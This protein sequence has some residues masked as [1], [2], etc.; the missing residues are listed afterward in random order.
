MRNKQS[1]KQTNKLLS[2]TRLRGSTRAT[3]CSKTDSSNKQTT[4]QANKQTIALLVVA[5][6]SGRQKDV[7]TKIWRLQRQSDP[8]SGVRW[9]LRIGNLSRA[10][11]PDDLFQRLFGGAMGTLYQSTTKADTVFFAP[12]PHRG[13]GNCFLKPNESIWV[14]V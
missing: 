6:F 1:K 4:K 12:W 9:N 3:C 7:R 8:V 11:T 13:A 5:T 2:S 10:R 14:C